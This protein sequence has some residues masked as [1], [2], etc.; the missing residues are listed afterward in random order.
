VQVFPGPLVSLRLTVQGELPG[1]ATK[2]LT[3]AMLAGALRAPPFGPGHAGQRRAHRARLGVRVHAE[4][5]TLKRDFV[6]LVRVEALIGETR[7]FVSGTVLGNR[8]G[9]IVEL[10]HFLLDAI[11]DGSILVTLHLDRPGV[12]GMIGTVLGQ[13]EIKHRRACSSG[14]RTTTRGRARDL[15]PVVALTAKALERAAQG[16]VI[17]QAHAVEN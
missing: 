5:S 3:V 4:A 16:A 9:R 15:E 1:S 6:S 11:V 7:H 13:E 17:V 8:H 12:I 2:P 10:D 14:R